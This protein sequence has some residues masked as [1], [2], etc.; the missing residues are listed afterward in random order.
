MVLRVDSEKG[1]AR[2]RE[3]GGKWAARAADR[4]RSQS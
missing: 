4:F 2:R 3:P 1:P